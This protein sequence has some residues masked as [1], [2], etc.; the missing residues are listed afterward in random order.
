MRKLSFFLVAAVAVGAVPAHPASAQDPVAM[1]GPYVL[2]S[3]SPERRVVVAGG[4][5]A[6]RG[7][8][9]SITVSMI[10]AQAY[11][12]DQMSRIDMAHRFDCANA[13]Y[14]IVASTAYNVRGAVLQNWTGDEGWKAVDPTGP[15]G[16]MM[17]YACDGTV[18]P[19]PAPWTGDIAGLTA[20]YLR[21]PR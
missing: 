16:K 20:E 13:R 3:S 4:T 1:G 21:D 15:G 14:K 18:P 10:V 12:A 7:G 9:A 17:R 11:L 8:E 5:R 19:G 6:R 2:I